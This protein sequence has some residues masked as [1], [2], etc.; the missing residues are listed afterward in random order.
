MGLCG[1]ACSTE[2]FMASTASGTSPCPVMTMTGS[3]SPISLRRRSK[4]IPLNPGVRTS[5]MMH[6]EP[7]AGAT[8][9]KAEA[10]SC[11]VP[12]RQIVAPKKYLGRWEQPLY[13]LEREAAEARAARSATSRGAAR[14][15][16]ARTLADKPEA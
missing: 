11:R 16:N 15:C 3:R 12:H 14:T 4:S 13:G 10:V 6:P 8:A 2:T 9:R 5:V 7:T 1:G